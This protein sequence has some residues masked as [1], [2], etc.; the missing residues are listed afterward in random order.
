MKE[1]D[2]E[3]DKFFKKGADDLIN[4]PVYRETDWDA[5]EQLL[6]QGKKR[7][8]VVYW[9]PR[10]GSVAAVLLLALFAWMFFKPQ[11]NKTNKVNS[12]ATVT[13]PDTGTSGGT[14][15]HEMADSS[16][17]KSNPANMAQNSV[18]PGPGK[19]TD[20]SFPYQPDG[21][22][23]K[24]PGKAPANVLAQKTNV[25]KK[26]GLIDKRDAATPDVVKNNDNILAENSSVVPGN[27]KDIGTADGKK[28]NA[29]SN[30]LAANNA[31]VPNDK[32]D[33]GTGDAHKNNG[34]ANSLAAAP[35]PK[36]KTTGLSNGINRPIFAVTAIASSDMNG[37]S[38]LNSGRL[39]GNLGALFSVSSG[40]WTFS[41]GGMYSIKPY[42][43]SFAD[44]HTQYHF[45]TAP[46]S[47][48]AN[49]RMID[50][51]LNVNYQVYRKGINKFTVGTGL[52]SYI[53]LR[54]DYNFNYTNPYAYGPAGYSVV[55][56]NRNIMSILNLD[57]TYERQI[58][59]RFGLV[60]QPYYKLPLTDVGASQ[61]KLQS[62][63]IA[64]GLNWNLNTFKKP[65]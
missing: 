63:G 30:T 1:K 53:I 27:K 57:V 11:P 64:V 5:M 59:S 18:H 61:V 22:A 21:N 33:I 47:V 45:Q 62:T 37:T 54:E 12:V 26:P 14:A 46:T 7:G 20:R 3:L 6:D 36:V 23:A 32:K 31:A 38:P 60:L 42:Q 56:R 29:D 43:E 8:G 4:E 35:K 52:S 2:E 51:P 10:L 24:M 50:I 28:N 55:N 13:K 39:G 25:D 16:K 19:K 34:D 15:R 9:L 44:Y 17:Q 65:N 40:K 41:T 58:N 48:G 49:C